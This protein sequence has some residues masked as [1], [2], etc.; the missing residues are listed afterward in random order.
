MEKLVLQVMDDLD[1]VSVAAE[2][3]TLGFNGKT[4]KLDLGEEASHQLRECITRFMRAGTAIDM[5]EFASGARRFRPAP[6]KK[7]FSH[8]RHYDLA[9][10][11]W[12]G[13]QPEYRDR[14]NSKGYV[15]SDVIEAYDHRADSSQEQE[16]PS[17]RTSRRRA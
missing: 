7:H 2:R 15:P 9:I 12:A 4:V 1:G 16:I 17:A 8:G 11:A 14:L 6:K 5:E 13:E 3:V 10:R